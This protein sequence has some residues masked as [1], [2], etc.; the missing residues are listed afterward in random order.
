MSV[1]DFIATDVV[2]GAQSGGVAGGVS[3]GGGSSSVSC[4]SGGTLYVCYGVMAASSGPR[5]LATSSCNVCMNC[6]YCFPAGPIRD[7]TVST[8]FVG[9]LDVSV[10]VAGVRHYEHCKLFYMCLNVWDLSVDAGLCH[11]D[12]NLLCINNGRV[13]SLFSV[14]PT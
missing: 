5:A 1:C 10:M 2:G 11:V 12:V 7:L 13:C 3:L 8:G 6:R 4:N 9:L 14:P